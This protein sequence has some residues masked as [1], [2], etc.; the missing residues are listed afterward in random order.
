LPLALSAS[1]RFAVVAPI[2]DFLLRV[3]FPYP[4]RADIG[5]PFLSSGE[6]PWFC[7]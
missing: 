6:T 2:S 5:G 1:L 7:H 3:I 4:F